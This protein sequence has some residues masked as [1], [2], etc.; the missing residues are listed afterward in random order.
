M[1]QLVPFADDVGQSGVL[2][3]FQRF[4]KE[5]RKSAALAE[6]YDEPYSGWWNPVHHFLNKIGVEALVAPV[7]PMTKPCG[8]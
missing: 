2:Q 7:S 8:F 5:Q 4:I 1:N 6:L 3:D